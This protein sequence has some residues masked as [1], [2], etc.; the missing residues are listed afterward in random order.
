MPFGVCL[1]LW[2]SVAVYAFRPF[3]LIRA[4]ASKCVCVRECVL[5]VC[6]D[7][8]VHWCRCRFSMCVIVALAYM[9]RRY[10]STIT[11]H[12]RMR[13]R[14]GYVT[15]CLCECVCMRSTLQYIHVNYL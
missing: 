14:C 8:M 6:I 1:E 3:H 15:V 9:I 4:P 5:H 10:V 7:C 13:I 11:Y 2:H 12:M